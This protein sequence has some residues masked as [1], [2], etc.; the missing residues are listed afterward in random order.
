MPT[1]SPALSSRRR[2]RQA[3]FTLIELVVVMAI[4]ALLAALVGPRLMDSLSDSQ[5]KTT[6]TQVELL[7]TALDKFRLDNGRY[8]TTEEGLT[9]LVDK[10]DNLATWAGPYLRKRV[11][12]QDGWGNAFLYERPATRGGI[13]YDLYS[14]GADGKPGGEGQAADLGNW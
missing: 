6:Q 5:V 13:E 2:R 11:V 9:A 12:P 14:L 8:P 7:G 3:G 1:P 10:P 4:I